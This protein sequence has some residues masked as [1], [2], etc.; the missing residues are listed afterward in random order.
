MR[1]RVEFYAN[2][3]GIAIPRFHF[4]G[5]KVDVLETVDRWHGP[6]YCYIKVKGHDGTVYILRLDETH[7]EWELTMFQRAQD[8]GLTA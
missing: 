3:H 1:V 6:D 2:D 4:D 5:R 8:Q 7:A